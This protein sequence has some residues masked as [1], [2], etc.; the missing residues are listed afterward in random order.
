MRSIALKELSLTIVQEDRGRVP[1]DET[2]LMKFPHVELYIANAVRC[3]AFD[4]DGPLLDTNV[5][6]VINRVFSSS[7]LGS[8]CVKTKNAKA[9]A[10]MVPKGRA[11]AFNLS[12]LDF[13]ASIRLPKCPKCPIFNTCDYGT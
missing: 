9:V 1:K 7:L 2:L 10:N 3:L 11:R 4:V 12:I 6:K 13:A 5:A 8:G